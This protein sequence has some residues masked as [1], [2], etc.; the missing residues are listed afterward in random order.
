MRLKGAQPDAHLDSRAAPIA[1][2]IRRG[3]LGIDITRPIDREDVAAIE[4]G[5]TRMPCWSFAAMT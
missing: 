2:G 5:W 4:G 1:P 3:G